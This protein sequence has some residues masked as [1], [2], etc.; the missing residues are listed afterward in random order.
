MSVAIETLLAGCLDAD[1]WS[2]DPVRL[3]LVSSDVYSEGVLAVAVVS[4]KDK[5]RCAAVIGTLTRAGFAIVGRGGGMS[6]TGGYLPTRPNTVVVDTSRLDRIVEINAENLYITVE[7][8]VTWKRIHE[9]LKPLGL[10]LPFFGTFSG[11]QATI[12]GGL[13]NGAL[14]LGTARYGTGAD[15]MLGMEIALADG[16]ILHTGQRAFSRAVQPF[17]RTYG[18]DL[19]GL[20]AHESGAF[21][22]KLQ[23][24]FK[25]IRTPAH[26]GYASFVFDGMEAA[27]R[28][29]SEVARTGAA[30]EAYV[31]D[32]ASTRKN[33]RSAGLLSDAGKL[34]SV[35]KAER[36]WWRGL[37]AGAKLAAAG[38]GFLPDEAYSLHVVCTARSE[39]ALRDELAAVR[40]ACSQLAGQEIPDSIPR[41]VRADLFPAPDGVLGPDG[42][43][44]AALNAKVAHS[45]ANAII[46]ASRAALEPYQRRMKDHGVWMSHLLIAIGS[47]AFSFE[48][49]FHWH[50]RWLPMHEAMPSAQTLARLPRPTP[51]PEATQLVAELREVLIEVFVRLGAA[52][53]Q[54]G[55]TYPYMPVLRDEPRELL[56][57]IKRWV[58][59]QGLM[60]PGGLGF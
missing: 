28:A 53:N 18:P 17:Y 60:N 44:W 48:P 20:F 33:L 4:P 36:S 26:T 12:G 8:G 37:W 1:E 55:K 9:A 54:I 57:E 13:S 25:L 41:A 11:A 42:D 29:L 56:G 59:P 7:A 2:V 51:N 14:F 35:V 31:F 6:Y 22:I 15:C 10:R 32:P 23:A 30:E 58:D 16:R 38:R 21:G 39:A 40:A 49:V 3:A 34:L 5:A 47:N 19:S 46:R 24:T 52:S 45:E 50:D 27:G 43:R